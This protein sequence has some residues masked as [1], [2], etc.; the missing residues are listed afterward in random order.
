MFT[1][2]EFRIKKPI[3][4]GLTKHGCTQKIVYIITI[5]TISFGPIKVDKNNYNICLWRI[6]FHLTLLI[7]CFLPTGKSWRTPVTRW[8]TICF[9]CSQSAFFDGKINAVSLLSPAINPSCSSIRTDLVSL[10]EKEDPCLPTLL[11]IKGCK[12]TWGSIL[13]WTESGLFGFDLRRNELVWYSVHMDEP[14]VG[15]TS[16]RFYHH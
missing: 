11:C 1:W 8:P 15:F 13:F 14:L 9:L 6:D 4:N 12:H 5:K 2:K 3:L 7:R 10:D 16:T